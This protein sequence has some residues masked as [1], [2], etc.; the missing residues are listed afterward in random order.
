L[1]GALIAGLVTSCSAMV[2]RVG[3]QS[4]EE[5]IRELERQVSAQA[6]EIVRLRIEL[7]KALND[8]ESRRQILVE[9]LRSETSAVRA[10]ALMNLMVEPEASART[11]IKPAREIL[12]GNGASIV[13]VRAVEFLSRFRDCHPGVVAA[14]S[15][16]SPEVRIAAAEGL[17]KFPGDLTLA[18]LQK[19]LEDPAQKVRLAAIDTIGVSKHERAGEVILEALAKAQDALVLERGLKALGTL[20]VPEAFDL[21]IR[22]LN[23]DNEGVRWASIQA[24]GALGDYRAIKHVRPFLDLQV[25]PSLRE[26][27]IQTLGHLKDEGSV[28]RLLEILRTDQD[29]NLQAATCMALGEIRDPSALSPLLDVFSKGKGD[30]TALRAWEAVVA[31]AGEDLARQE[32]LVLE[33]I[34]RRCKAEAE[35]IFRSLRE[36]HN[37]ENH[38]IRIKDVQVALARF[39]MD[40]GDHGA[41][42]EHWKRIVTVDSNG[43]HWLQLGRC[44]RKVGDLETALKTFRDAAAA[45]KPENPMTRVLLLEVVAT[46]VSR[47]DGAGALAEVDRITRIQGL[48]LTRVDRAE[49]ERQITQVVRLLLSDLRSNDEKVKKASVATLQAHG[50]LTIGP[51]IHAARDEANRDLR[52]SVIEI[53][54]AVTGSKIDPVRATEDEP[55][56]RG[57]DLWSDWATRNPW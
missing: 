23:H 27:A 4:Q 37:G 36:T 51:I 18:T 41:A 43:L 38:K 17:K 14:A 47:K 7:A 11:F 30:A 32:S 35:E 46:L 45:A 2:P 21:F 50:R 28:P 54:N 42:L 57:L 44:Y 6:V 12:A 24:I 26:I 48:E 13:R 53:C 19:L 34:E 25:P 31:I 20:K 49:L 15:D 16:K 3:S 52:P 1:I 5:R 55:F 56:K 8:D 10:F 40:E 33:L 22:H 29:E 39:L 9:S